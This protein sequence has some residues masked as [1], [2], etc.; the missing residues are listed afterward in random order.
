MRQNI[1]MDVGKSNID[2]C[3]FKQNQK[4]IFKKFTNCSEGFQHLL[5]WVL[6]TS[7]SNP[8]DILVTLE[9][10]GVYHERLASF[11]Y[12]SEFM[13]FIANPGKAKKFALS[14]GSIHKTDKGDSLMLARFGA[15][16]EEIPKLW[17]PMNPMAQDLKAMNHRLSALEKDFLRENNRLEAATIG[18]QSQLTIDSINRMIQY[19]FQEISIC[20]ADIDALIESNVVLRN[21]KKLLMSIK[22][23]GP[24]MARELVSL[25]AYKDFKNAKQ[26]AAYLGLIPQINESGIFKGRTSLSKNGPSRIRAKLYLAAVKAF[27]HNPDIKSQKERLLKAGKTKMQALG[28]AMRK[29]V[30]ICF[31]VIKSQTPYTPQNII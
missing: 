20:K 9:A 16:H 10:T 12:A 18:N 14:V 1:G 29:L 30:Q 15:S 25:F 2:V 23:I 31:G 8:N 19:L 11:L 5:D 27:T 17:M 6:V 28:A 3:I 13:V 26:L 21:N 24:V 22:G 7:S 4:P